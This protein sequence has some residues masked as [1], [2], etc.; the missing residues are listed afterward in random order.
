[1]SAKIYINDSSTSSPKT[2]FHIFNTVQ[3]LQS[4]ESVDNSAFNLRNQ[5]GILLFNHRRNENSTTK[6]KHINNSF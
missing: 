1:M 6:I 2:I 4:N 5:S 3:N